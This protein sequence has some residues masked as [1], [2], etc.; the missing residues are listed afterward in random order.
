MGL[1]IGKAPKFDTRQD[2]KCGRTTEGSTAIGKPGYECGTATTLDV[3]LT[4]HLSIILVIN[5]L[6]T[7]NISLLLHR[8]FCRITL[9]HQLMHL[10][11]ISH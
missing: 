1:L 7:Q 9:S 5:Q 6:N 8:A 4:M 11:K 3:L 10:H 2:I